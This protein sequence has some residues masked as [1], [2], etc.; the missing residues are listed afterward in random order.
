MRGEAKRT[1]DDVLFEEAKK[2]DTPKAYQA[3]LAAKDIDSRH[4][5]QARR[6]HDM[7]VLRIASAES[8]PETLEKASGTF[9]DQDTFGP[10]AQA[11]ACRRRL[12]A[13]ADNIEGSNVQAFVSRCGTVEEVQV[14]VAHRLLSQSSAKAPYDKGT[15]DGLVV[16]GELAKHGPPALKEKG[17]AWLRAQESARLLGLS[18]DAGSIARRIQAD[19]K[20]P[21]ADKL[22]AH[23]DGLIAP[24]G[25]SKGWQCKTSDRSAQEHWL[26]KAAAY[27]EDCIVCAD[28]AQVQKA[29]AKT[30]AALIKGAKNACKKE[31]KGAI[32]ACKDTSRE[33]KK[34]CGQELKN[35]KNKRI[36]NSCADE[37]AACLIAY[38]TLTS[39]GY[40]G[41]EN[42][43]APKYASCIAPLKAE[44]DQCMRELKEQ[45][46]QCVTAA[47][48]DASTCTTRA[49]NIGKSDFEVCVALCQDSAKSKAAACKGQ[50][51]AAKKA[52]GAEKAAELKACTRT[53]SDCNRTEN[54]QMARA[55][56][57]QGYGVKEDCSGN[58]RECTSEIKNTHK[59]CMEQAADACSSGAKDCNESCS[60]FR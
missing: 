19:P 48:S 13:C 1:L 15:Y 51:A 11:E 49:A 14:R 53:K 17:E 45:E 18:E 57:A 3:Y 60:K 24:C 52:C 10:Q 25:P 5:K 55:M 7:A 27:L 6:G 47:K 2:A 22:K 31:S 20:L 44:A 34:E 26:T 54:S 21:D 41:F 12:A 33:A 38:R 37:K 8:G 35:A 46:R 32:K 59:D 28:K 9:I 30:L 23:H 36:P 58:Y 39:K 4:A 56:R 43:C 29:Q 50:I 16:Q 42:D 40:G